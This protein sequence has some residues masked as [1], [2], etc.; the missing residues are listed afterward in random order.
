LDDAWGMGAGVDFVG[1]PGACHR[2]DAQKENRY[3]RAEVANYAL[4]DFSKPA[5][6]A[7]IIG[8]I[9]GAAWFAIPLLT[10][11]RFAEPNLVN[12]AR[13]LPANLPRDRGD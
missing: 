6:H 9:F 3:Y 11:P 1:K 7:L 10:R 4:I 13:F 5:V 12:L 2:A 8:V